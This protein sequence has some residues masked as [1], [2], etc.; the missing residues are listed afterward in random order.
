MNRLAGI[1]IAVVG[2][3]LTILS[4]VK[5][6]AGLTS[7]GVCL[8]LLG[9][10]VIGLS[11]VPKPDPIETPRMSTP[12]TLAGMFYAPSEVFQNLR[13]HPR[14][15]VAVLTMSVLSAVFFNAFMYRLTPDRVTN[16]AI[17]KTLEMSMI[18][19]NE[20][21]R[22]GVE[23]GRAQAL[24]DNKNPV[25]R[26][27]QAVN[28]FVGQVFLYAFLA[29]VYF[30]FALAMGGQMN[31]WQAFSAAVYAAF[32]MSIIRFVL[33]S[34]I[35]FIKDP[36]DIHPIMGQTSL[37]QDSLNFLVAPAEHPVIFVLLSSF[38]LLMFYWVWLNSTGLKNAG[39]K[40]TSTIAWSATITIFVA[41]LLLGLVSALLFPSFIS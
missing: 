4:V 34:I 9:I 8:I 37:V 13:R 5:V 10:L 22:K 15:L 40:V 19:N 27:G 31:Y 6:T 24:E 20:E 29:A 12:E 36:I 1:V 11:F 16:Y 17:D 30:V 39:E 14:W 32:P 3:L 7:T 21:A 41:L 38:S 28:G 35:L 23:V 26:A 2:L 18:A 25:L 33:S